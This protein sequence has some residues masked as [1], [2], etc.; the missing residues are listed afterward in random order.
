MLNPDYQNGGTY[1]VS[2]WLDKLNHELRKHRQDDDDAKFTHD[3]KTGLYM[4]RISDWKYYSRRGRIFKQRNGV[5]P[6]K[7]FKSAKE[8]LDCL[9]EID[10]MRKELCAITQPAGSSLAPSGA[11]ALE[12]DEIPD[13]ARY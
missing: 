3:P 5:Y 8:A 7:E 4:L 9:S 6:V 2:V 12:D 1:I 11:K 13:H 10:T